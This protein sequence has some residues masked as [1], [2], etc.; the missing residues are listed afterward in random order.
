LGELLQDVEAAQ[1]DDLRLRT[2]LTRDYLSWRYVDVPGVGYC[3]AAVNDAAGL[4]GL[5]IGRM[6]A[7]GE[8]RELTLTELVTRPGDRLGLR[9]LLR[10][11]VRGG[12]DHVATVW[13][14]GSGTAA[15]L[16]G[17]GFLRMPGATLTM[18]ARPLP[19]A[20]DDIPDVRPAASWALHLGDLELF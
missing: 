4:R 5:A 2:R 20:P 6:R 8:L 15:A 18:T 1:R 7:R 13:P 17:R 11:V 10:E 19:G 3:Y 12:G 9:R 16:S 14:R